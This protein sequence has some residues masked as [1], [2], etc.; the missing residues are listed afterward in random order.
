[1]VSEQQFVLTE[2]KKDRDWSRNLLTN[3]KMLNRM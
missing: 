3:M 1:M 2:V